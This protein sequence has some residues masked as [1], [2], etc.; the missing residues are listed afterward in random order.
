V[1]PDTLRKWEQRY[2]IL[3]PERTR[4]GQ[5]RYSERDVARVEWLRDRLDEGYRISEAARI[6]GGPDVDPALSVDEL[7]ALLMQALG[8][9]DAGRLGSLVDQTFATLP[10][11]EALSRVVAPL[12][13][14]IGDA[15]VAGE[16][17]VAQEHLLSSKIRFRLEQLVGD[18]RG[19]VRG[20][21][22]LAC[23]PG[24]RHELGLLMLAVL[25]RAD[26][27][28]VEYLG[29]DT[30]AGQAL[31]LAR[32]V[33]AALVCFSSATKETAAELARQLKE[34][35]RDAHPK[36]VVGG[37]GVNARFARTVGATYVDTDL[38]A[39][40]RELRTLAS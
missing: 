23:A 29:A 18:T 32:A 17:S 8:D 24:E 35:P 1:A 22:V 9:N 14:L 13:G 37:H 3:N 11:Q 36:L 30:P 38:A 40:V 5:R 12:L 27:W 7:P 6:L 28:R 16:I 19:G 33:D 26:G 10:T 4:G 31:V 20:V 39:S 21:A 25:L 34:T 15:W 2:G